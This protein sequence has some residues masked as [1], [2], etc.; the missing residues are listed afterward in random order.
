MGSR[1][2]FVHALPLPRG[3]RPPSR[4]RCGRRRAGAPRRRAP[5]AQQPSDG[6]GPRPVALGGGCAILAAVLLNRALLTPLDALPPPQARGDLLAVSAA[7]ALVLYGL[8]RAEVAERAA[9]PVDVGGVEVQVG[10]D[11]SGAA[12]Q[13]AWTARALF[14]GVPAVRS[15]ALVVD[16]A[17][18]Y[19]VGRFRDADAAA[20]APAGGIAAGVMESGRRAYL[21]DLKVVPVREVEFG[22]LP[23]LCQVRG[24]GRR[25]ARARA[26]CVARPLLAR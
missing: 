20:L 12:A 6:G 11:G 5:A 14:K 4:A 2:A 22:F 17:E 21:A 24:R 25:C 23:Q 3:A 26:P 19:R 13:A 10:L 7:A 16:G 18:V 1:G 15:F 9:A 8:G